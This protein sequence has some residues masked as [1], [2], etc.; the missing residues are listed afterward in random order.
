[1]PR[2]V[3]Q[4]QHLGSLDRLDHTHRW[5]G[6]TPTHRYLT[7][8][9][10]TRPRRSPCSHSELARRRQEPV[11][12]PAGRR[13]VG[14]RG[15]AV[16]PVLDVTSNGKSILMGLR[17]GSGCARGVVGF[18]STKTPYHC[19]KSFR[20]DPPL[21][22][23][24]LSHLRRSAGHRPRCGRRRRCG[25]EPGAAVQRGHGSSATAA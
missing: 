8:M 15:K 22:L 13:A 23:K 25:S 14:T 10:S 3:R 7:R 20:P 17:R 9:T 16:E 2:H 6:H 4:H 21:R 19:S 12:Q 11:R 5:V 18:S 1:M 24:G